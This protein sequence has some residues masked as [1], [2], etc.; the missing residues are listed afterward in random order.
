MND[1]SFAYFHLT[2]PYFTV[3]LLVHINKN[4]V[5]AQSFVSVIQNYGVWFWMSHFISEIW[6]LF[7]QL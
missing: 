3:K 6:L 7:Q 4:Y 5:P 2:V 1:G